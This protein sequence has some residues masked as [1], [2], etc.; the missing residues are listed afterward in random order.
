MYEKNSVSKRQ[1]DE[2][3]NRQ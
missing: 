2:S 1:S 3:L